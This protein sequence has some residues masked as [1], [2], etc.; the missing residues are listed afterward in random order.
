MSRDVKALQP[1]G[2]LREGAPHRHPEALYHLRVP[3]GIFGLSNQQHWQGTA[4]RGQAAARF[5]CP[6]SYIQTE[7]VVLAVVHE[8]LIVTSSEFSLQLDHVGDLPLM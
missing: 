3:A 1:E 2:R 7:C 6:V 8:S 4:N 5:K